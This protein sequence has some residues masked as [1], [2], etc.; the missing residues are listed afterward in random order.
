MT[1][2]E[3]G[4][5]LTSVV[6]AFGAV[7]I[8]VF[9]LT[10]ISA[11][12]SGISAVPLMFAA[13]FIILG[14]LPLFAPRTDR[15][16]RTLLPALAASG[17]LVSAGLTGF[18][19]GILVFPL[20]LLAVACLAFTLAISRSA[21]DVGGLAGGLVVGLAL[22]LL[23]V[24]IAP[25]LPPGCPQRP[26]HVSGGATYPSEGVEVTFECQDGRLTSWHVNH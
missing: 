9:Y 4:R 12:G 2:A 24:A 19:I 6:L 3:R 8:A 22:P 5:R 11:Q 7:A 15:P 26:G 14:S 17:W 20:A 16:W 13:L 18:S 21:M 1:R 25:Y 10:I 23:L